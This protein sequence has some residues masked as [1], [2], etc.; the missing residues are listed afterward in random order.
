MDCDLEKRFIDIEPIAC[1][2]VYREPYPYFIAK[3][4]IPPKY[5]KEINR[6]FPIIRKPGFFPSDVIKSDGSFN[7]LLRD[8]KSEEFT[9]LLGN[10]L[11]VRLCDKPCLITVR[12]LSALKDGRIHNDGEAK[13]ATALLYL[14]EEWPENEDGGRLR[15]LYNDKDFDD[16]AAEVS[17]VFGEFIAFVRT[18]NSWHGHKPFKGERRVIQITW[19]RSY[20]DYMRKTKR[21]RFSF[22]VKNFIPWKYKATY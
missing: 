18:N 6:D 13:I 19:L 7:V 22:F 14:N 8:L 4:V 9:R 1:A 3:S 15:I 11:G 17:P 2:N 10:K 20:E 21:G 5:S 16:S 12:K